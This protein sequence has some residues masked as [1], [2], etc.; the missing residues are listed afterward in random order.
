MIASS[1]MLHFVK[2]FQSIS[3]RK[4]TVIMHVAEMG[5]QKHQEVKQFAQGDRTN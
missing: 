5:K 3:Q 1:F 4:W 2:R